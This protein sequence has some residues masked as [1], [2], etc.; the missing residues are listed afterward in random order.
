M[1]GM[2]YWIRLA[3]VMA[4]RGRGRR[5]NVRFCETN[6]IQNGGF[7][8]GTTYAYDICRE[9][10]KKMNPVRLAKPNP[11]G[12]GIS[13]MGLMVGRWKNLRFTEAQLQLA[14]EGR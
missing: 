9:T 13:R 4:D 14:G 3:E 10:F 12:R 1:W 6:R 11:F 2:D 8:D 5:E 7:F